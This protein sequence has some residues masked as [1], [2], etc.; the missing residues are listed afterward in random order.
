VVPTIFSVTVS[1]P[2][3]IKNMC[4]FTY[5]KQKVPDNSEVHRSLQ[6]CGSSVGLWN[7]FHDTF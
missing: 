4:Q 1:F 3:Y 7:L 6:R 2:P 5:T